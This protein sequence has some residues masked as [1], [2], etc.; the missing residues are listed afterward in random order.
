[1]TP[2]NPYLKSSKPIDTN[3]MANWIAEHKPNYFVTLTFN[4][5]YRADIADEKLKRFGAYWDRRLLG[6]KWYKKPIEERTLFF[7]FAEHMDSNFHYHLAVKV[8][9]EH[10]KNFDK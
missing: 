3:V 1:M 6:R 8:R 7:A 4:D 5:F 10:Q 2:Q 9:K